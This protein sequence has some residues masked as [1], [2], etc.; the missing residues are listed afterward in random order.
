MS[1]TA[2]NVRVAVTGAALVAPLGTTIPTDATTAPGSTF[3]DTGY[4]HEDGVT[5]AIGT[6]MSDIKAWQ[7]G[8]VVRKIQTAHDLTFQ[9]TMIETTVTTLKIYYADKTATA[10]AVKVT[11]AQS[12][13]NA[14]V[15]EVND[16]DNTIRVVL[17]DA[18]V[19]ERGDITYKTDEAIGYNITLTAYADS[20]GVKAYIY[21]DDGA[22]EAGA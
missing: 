4:I 12:E 14:W 3:N 17:P 19:T 16:G 6:E 15:L 10:T 9:F 8:D 2:E 18:Q 5:Q 13:H 22:T 21:L 7:N 11:A 20:D 1:L